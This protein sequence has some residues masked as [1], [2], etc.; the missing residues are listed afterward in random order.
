MSNKAV[1]KKF[2]QKQRGLLFRYQPVTALNVKKM[3]FRV[4]MSCS[5]QN[6]DVSETHVI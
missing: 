2:M 3:V 5:S 6:P 1:N 4:I